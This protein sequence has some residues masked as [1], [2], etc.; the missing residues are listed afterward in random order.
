MIRVITCTF[1]IMILFTACS[2]FKSSADSKVIAKVG[3][4]YLYAD[5]LPVIAG[6]NI[7]YE[8]SIS[9]S[10]NYIDR[11][12]KKELM[13]SRAAQ[14]LTEE[15]L[16]EMNKKLEETRS[17]LMIYQYQQQMI[18]QRM[19]TT[20]SEQMVEDYYNEHIGNFRLSHPVVKALYMKIPVEAPNID[21]LR[22]WYKNLTPQNI[23]NIESYCYQFADKYDDF[24]ENWINISLLLRG[25]PADLSNIDRF[26]RNNR[27]YETSDSLFHYF[28]NITDF[29]LSGAEA[30]IEYVSGDIRNIIIN[31]RKIGFLQDLE[32]GIYNEA[33]KSN[34][35]K[36][37]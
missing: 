26:V 35:F 21:R 4:Q 25:L 29:R 23:Q 19:D 8:D 34:L 16:N 3:D 33:L 10:R 13:V 11:W 30:P 32:N 37:Y 27:Y 20:V 28:V 12:I 17:N 2:D 9:I 5:D 1:T 14:N 36:I 24:G 7:S 18:V 22:Q 15:Y 6:N 31:N